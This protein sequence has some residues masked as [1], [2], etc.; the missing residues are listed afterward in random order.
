MLQPQRHSVFH[1]AYISR[2]SGSQYFYAYF[3]DVNGKRRNAS[4]HTADRA[5]AQRIAD[6]LEKATSR[7]YSSEHI[8]SLF[9]KIYK[10]VYQTELPRITVRAF[11]EQWLEQVKLQVSQSAYQSYQKATNR[12][13][14][15]LGTKADSDIADITEG[16]LINVRSKMAADLLASSVNNYL[17]P[18]KRIFRA[19]LREKYLSHNP[20]EFLEPIKASP[21]E[22]AFR[23]QAFS[24]EH[25]QLL[26]RI[27]DPEWASMIRF[28][29]YTSQRLGDV[30]RLTWSNIDLERDE[31][32]LSTQKT[33]RRMTIPIAPPLKAHLLE[34]PSKDD[35]AAPL[36]PQA[37]RLLENE[38]KIT[39]LSRQF[40]LLLIRAGLREPI[41]PKLPGDR[42]CR[43]ALSFHSLRH[44][45][46]SM[47]KAAGVAH[48]TVQEFVGHS[49][50]AV[51]QLY[52]HVDLNALK[53]A[54]DTFPRL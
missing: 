45:A 13:C 3:R 22:K 31:I 12:L 8:R 40:G 14:D 5:Q 18:I 42:L 26:L 43:H 28:G 20:A 16:D 37:F 53:R 25:I 6:A 19:A 36:H 2:K 11:T 49:S 24:L 44:S 15:A 10:E 7:K 33:G 46:V 30:A 27:A 4:T 23:R 32:H 38:G 9:E 51:S 29:L 34:L 52:T 1:M 21:E 39:T 48:A 35:P 17:N 50:A 47:L 54:T 41:T